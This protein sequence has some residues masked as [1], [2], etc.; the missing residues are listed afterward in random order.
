[1]AGLA[2]NPAERSLWIKLSQH[3]LRMIPRNDRS[4]LKRFDAA[5]DSTGTGQ[6]PSEAEH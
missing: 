1:M 2:Q 3:W 4:A 6:T 5:V